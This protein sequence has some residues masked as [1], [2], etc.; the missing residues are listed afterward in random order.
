[1]TLAREKLPFRW[2]GYRKRDVD[3]F[4]R[5]TAYLQRLE[6][7]EVE[8]QIR[9]LRA[10]N[11]RL[12]A[13]KEVSPDREDLEDLAKIS[14]E[15]VHQSQ[16][17]VEAGWRSELQRIAAYEQDAREFHLHTVA[18]LERWK[19]E[20]AEWLRMLEQGTD[21]AWQSAREWL[22]EAEMQPVDIK[23]VEPVE[24]P[25]TEIQLRQ[26]FRSA[27]EVGLKAVEISEEERKALLG[28]GSEG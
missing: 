28:F 12:I 2:F 8:L 19:T 6:A 26:K 24:G 4:F 9:K 25:L 16:Q 1:M 3:A 23:T 15:A 20:T 14:E 7:E 22:L 10:V 27:S 21:D 17:M 18:V 11:E 5:Q 13:E